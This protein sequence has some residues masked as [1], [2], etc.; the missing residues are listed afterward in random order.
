MRYPLSGVQSLKDVV[1]L[2][3]QSFAAQKEFPARSTRLA[4]EHGGTDAGQQQG[5]NARGDL[6]I[7]KM[8]LFALDDDTR[9]Q[10]GDGLLVDLGQARDHALVRDGEIVHL[11]L[12]TLQP[13]AQF[14]QHVRAFLQLAS[15]KIRPTA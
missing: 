14:L 6:G 1:R 8:I 13:V 10:L 7:G 15:R 4:P 11:P 9:T 3:N 5:A 2:A 12:G